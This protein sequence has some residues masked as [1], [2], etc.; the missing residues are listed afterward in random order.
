MFLRWVYKFAP[1]FDSYV[2]P[3]KDKHHYWIGL[4]LLARLVLILTSAV[5]MTTLPFVSAAVLLV[6]VTVLCLLVLSVYK[7]WLLGVLEGAFLVNLIVFSSGALVI[8]LQ[9]GNKDTF[10]CISIGITF[11]LFLSITGYHV[12]KRLDSLIRKRLNE[13]HGY[14]DIDIVIRPRQPP[15]PPQQRRIESTLDTEI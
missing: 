14:E 12:W 7:R 2:G 9:E 5:T 3:L 10:A 13:H 4:G 6:T 15:T 8:E 11:A 1:F